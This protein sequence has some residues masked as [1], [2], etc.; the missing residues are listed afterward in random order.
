MRAF[1]ANYLLGRQGD[2]PVSLEELVRITRSD[3]SARGIEEAAKIDL[4]E[5]GAEQVNAARHTYLE[6]LAKL[7][8][9]SVIK[10]HMPN[11][12]AQDI[13][14]VPPTLTKCAIYVVRNPL[15]VVSSF[16]DQLGMS[17]EEAVEMMGSLEARLSGVE[18]QIQ[19]FLGNWSLHV[20]SWFA[21]EGFPVQVLRYEDM[22]DD[23][24]KAFRSVLD[25]LGIRFDAA[26][27]AHAID[28]SSFDQLKALEERDGFIERSKKQERFFRQ[29]KKGMG[30]ETLPTAIKDKLV[31]DHCSVMKVLKYLD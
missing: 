28:M 13:D 3:V 18:S 30:S 26:Q 17:L 9:A 11:V 15:D 27:M 8:V 14:L 22:L 5:C 23:P 24:A 1:L 10:T 4:S 6:S 20:R 2:G 29:G 7:D 19:S 25:L 12:S 21:T 31:A 16:A